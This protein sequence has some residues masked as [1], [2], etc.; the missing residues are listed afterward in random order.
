MDILV[1]KKAKYATDFHN[2]RG[3]LYSES[4]SQH[5]N[6]FHRDKDRVIHSEHFRLLK[7]KTQVFIAHTEDYYR[8]RLTHS[9]EVSQ[10]ARTVAR[11]LKLDEDLSEVLALSHD[12]GH[13]PFSHSGEEALDDCMKDFGGFDHNV[14]T[15]KIVTGLEKRYPDF[16]GLNL[17]WETLEGILKHN[18]P[19]KNYKS[20][21]PIGFFA[22]DFISNYDLEIS[23]FASLEAQISS[24]SDD[25]AYNNHDI[26]DG[27]R[28]KKFKIK[29][30]C[31]I[32]LIDKIYKDIIK[33]YTGLDDFMVI[34][35]LVRRLIGF[36]VNDLLEQTNKN[37]EILKPQ[38]VV[39]IRY[40]DHPIA[41]FSNKMKEQD[42]ELRKFLHERV[43]SHSSMDSDRNNG[44][45]IIKELFDK[46]LTNNDL[47][48]I[49]IKQACDDQSL[50][51]KAIIICDFIASMTD[52]SA[53]ANHA[54]VIAQEML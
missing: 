30:I 19:I 12:L 52:R 9:I 47:L 44:R 2:S 5:R 25:I 15:L 26:D 39:D 11:I 53:T 38:S 18:G 14:Q 42:K 8:T 27:F 4:E 1:Y 21:S 3:R 29:D 35:E 28:A 33:E 49:K 54:K 17:C 24:L 48:P 51:K 16:D 31:E 13:P 6:P 50:S 20:K 46:L 43:Y 37:L 23:T 22:R 45:K 32:P 34:Q 10:I 41:A 36:M 7:H 40:H